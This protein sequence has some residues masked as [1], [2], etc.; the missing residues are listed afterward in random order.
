MTCQH[1]YQFLKTRQVGSNAYGVTY[2]I[3][4]CVA[5]GWLKTEGQ[6]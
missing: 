6:K 2:R 4:K 1:T 3:F 5:C